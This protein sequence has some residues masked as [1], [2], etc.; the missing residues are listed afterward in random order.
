MKAKLISN[1]S[2][3]V[4]IF[5]A[6]WG[7]DDSQFSIL[8]SASDILLCWDYSDLN[9]DFDF[10]SYNSVDLI[11]YSAGVFISALIKDKFPILNKKIALNGNISL[12]DTYFGLEK[13]AL[14][15][16]YNLNADN[17][18]E[19]R[20]E[21]LVF[22]NIELEFFNKNSPIRVL[23]S[24]QLELKRLKEYYLS[25]KNISFKYDCALLSDKDRIFNPEHQKEFYKDN[26][27]I[28]KNRA[29]DI[30]FDFHNLDKIL[31][32]CK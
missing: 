3:R 23:E 16:M 28:L 20:K 25:N 9:F 14:N 18:M 29:H 4:I 6:G 8:S 30:F 13:D 15:A 5:M 2:D 22:N 1:D 10:S 32:I 7:C 12:F 31:S 19:F 17:Y 11:S 26:Y 24:C 21:F 27:I